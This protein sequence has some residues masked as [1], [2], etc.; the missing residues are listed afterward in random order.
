MKILLINQDWF[1][2]E[3]RAQGHE[4]LVASSIPEHELLIDAP[5]MPL[6]KLCGDFKP[7]RILVHDNSSPIMISGLEDTDIPTVFYS[8]DAQHHSHYHRFL[9]GAFD[10]TFVIAVKALVVEPI[11]KSVSGVTGRLRSTS[12]KPNPFT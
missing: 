11:S 12:L 3:W 1:A 7:D 2:P 9:A 4:V 8:V 10:L 5:L 6:T